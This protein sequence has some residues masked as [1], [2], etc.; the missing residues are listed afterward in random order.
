MLE[1]GIPFRLDGINS[2]YK[3]VIQPVLENGIPFC[4]EGINS[5]TGY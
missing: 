4:L 5:T 3:P 2:I 1:N